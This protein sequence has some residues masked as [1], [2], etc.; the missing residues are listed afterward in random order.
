[1]IKV[2]E[3]LNRYVMIDGRIAKVVK[4]NHKE[5]RASR[6][7]RKATGEKTEKVVKDVWWE[8]IDDPACLLH[9]HRYSYMYRWHDLRIEYLRLLGQFVTLRK[10]MTEEDPK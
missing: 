1:M 4:I 10:L 6:K 5:V 7:H 2:E 9:S 3:L 8:F